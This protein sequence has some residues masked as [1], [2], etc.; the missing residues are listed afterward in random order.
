MPV[1]LFTM[2]LERSGQVLKRLVVLR[3]DFSFSSKTS[4][5]P[6]IT[7][8]TPSKLL[9]GTLNFFTYGLPLIETQNFASGRCDNKIF[10]L[11]CLGEAVLTSSLCFEAK[12]KKI[13]HYI[14][15]R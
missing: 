8:L 7:G 1:G 10:R 15:R 6:L 5:P 3:L 2:L 11:H 9:T 14:I 12:N 13:V 4:L